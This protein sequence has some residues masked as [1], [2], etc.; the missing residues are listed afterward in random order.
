MHNREPGNSDPDTMLTLYLVC[1]AK[2]TRTLYVQDDWPEFLKVLWREQHPEGH[3]Q[4]ALNFSP[5]LP[6]AT[7][8][9][10]FQGLNTRT[11]KWR[12]KSTS[13]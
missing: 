12:R 6:Q 9:P 5:L 11:A 3:E 13:K 8:V 1:H 7:E 10:L 4:V 2:V